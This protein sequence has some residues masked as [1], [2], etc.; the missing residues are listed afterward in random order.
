[1]NRGL[2][3]RLLVALAGVLLFV[4]I[5][6]NTSWTEVDVPNAPGKQADDDRYYA[7]RR[8]LQAAGSTLTTTGDFEPLPPAGATLVLDSA[9]WDVFPERDQ[10]LRRWVE[11]G[12]HLV[13]SGAR[14]RTG[15]DDAPLKWVPVVYGTERRPPAARPP[16]ASAPDEDDDDEDQAPAPPVR[17]APGRGDR[18]FPQASPASASGS[19]VP[20]P[21]E[22]GQ[23]YDVSMASARLAPRRGIEPVWRMGAAEHPEVAVAME[24]AVGRGRV[25]AIGTA[26]PFEGRGLLRDDNALVT[27]GMLH[28]GPGHAVWILEDASGSSFVAWLWRV[29]RG[30]VLLAVVAVAAALWRLAVRFGPREMPPA[31][32][33]RSMGEQVRGM[34]EFILA[35]DPAALHGAARH[36][37]DEVARG[38]IDGY[39]SLDEDQRADALVA[40]LPQ[41]GRADAA[42]LRAAMDAS[43]RPA[44]AHWLAA[45]ETLEQARRALLRTTAYV[46]ATT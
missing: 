40:L 17:R 6:S 36:A 35:R 43:P 4:W 22:D 34:G 28:A 1:M 9:L 45:I 5:V 20:P 31:R 46:R 3:L 21:M 33:R 16:A 26:L 39:A 27:A 29:A 41:A 19:A 25:T 37:L 42:S 2:A 10:R 7:L 11:D 32:A 30:P 24:V 14:L 8:I 15:D 12:G 18:A 13:I 44:R 38:R 23:R